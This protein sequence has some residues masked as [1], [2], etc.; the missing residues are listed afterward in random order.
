MFVFIFMLP[1]CLLVLDKRL[2]DRV[3]DMLSAGLIE[4]LRDFHVQYNQQKVQDDR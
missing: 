1:L 3:D 2:D 4:E